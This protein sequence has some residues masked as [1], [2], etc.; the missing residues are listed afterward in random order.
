MNTKEIVSLTD[1]IYNM[2]ECG[3][4]VSCESSDTDR[5]EDILIC[6]DCGYGVTIQDE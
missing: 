3:I 2:I 1:D 6:N 5:W 4:C